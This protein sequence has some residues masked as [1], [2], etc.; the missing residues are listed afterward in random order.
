MERI[1]FNGLEIIIT[2][3]PLSDQ[4]IFMKREIDF[5]RQLM[6]KPDGSNLILLNKILSGATK[7]NKGGLALEIEKLKMI[8][9]ELDINSLSELE[10][11]ILEEKKML[12]DYIRNG[13]NVNRPGRSMYVN[14]ILQ[15]LRK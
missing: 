9:K 8:M 13:R 2:D 12:M 5:A 3:R 15:R 11:M 14:D 6:D 1:S 10:E 4:P 7:A